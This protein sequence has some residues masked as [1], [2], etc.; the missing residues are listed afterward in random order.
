M[1]I[2]LKPNGPCLWHSKIPIGGNDWNW[3]QKPVSFGDSHIERKLMKLPA[4]REHR[5]GQIAYAA[6]YL[7]T[8]ATVIKFAWW[9]W[10]QPW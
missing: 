7:L 5:A 9:I 10:S 2:V 6:G 8:L 1:Q 3:M 4:T